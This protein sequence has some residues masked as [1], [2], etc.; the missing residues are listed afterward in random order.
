MNKV[1]VLLVMLMSG[2][3]ALCGEFTVSFVQDGTL[4]RIQDLFRNSGLVTGGNLFSSA[5]YG[6]L[7]TEGLFFQCNN[8]DAFSLGAINLDA[9]R[10]AGKR[11]QVKAE[12]KRSISVDKKFQ[13]GKL[14]ITY[15]ANGRSEWPGA[16]MMPGNFDWQT[17]NLDCTVPVDATDVQLVM[18]IQNGTGEVTYRSLS[19]RIEDTIVDLHTV[20]NMEYAD[21]VAGDGKGGW[22]DQGRNND[23]SGF[24]YSKKSFAGIPF[25]PLSPG[26]PHKTILT[27]QSTRF[28]NGLQEAVCPVGYSK[29]QGKYIYLLHT[30]TWGGGETGAV[31]FVDIVGSDN[32]M[33]TIPVRA[34]LDVGDWWHATKRPNGFPAGSWSNNEGGIVSLYASRFKLNEDLGDI[35][36]VR[37]RSANS[38]A[39]WIVVAATISENEYNFPDANAVTITV[40]KEWGLPPK[41]SQTAGIRAGS[42]LDL[43]PLF[44]AQPVDHTGRVV[45]NKQGLLAY[46]SAPEKPVR[47]LTDAVL[48]APFTGFRNDALELSDKDATKAYV[49]ELVRAGYNMVRFHFMDDNIM[50]NATNEFEFHAGIQDKFDYLVYCMKQK[51]IYISLDAMARRIGYSSGNN[52]SPGKDD[53]RN[54]K[55]DIYFNPIVRDNW[56]KGVTKFLSHVNPYT[57]MALKDDPALA[58]IVGYNEQEFAWSVRD[59]SGATE[60]WRQYLRDKYRDIHNLNDA[61]KPSTPYQSFTDIPTP[62]KKDA[63]SDSPLG[64][65]FDSFIFENEVALLQWYVATLRK[66]GTKALVANFNCGQDL[67]RMKT[68]SYGDFVAMN[69]YH[70][71]P[72]G[73]ISDPR[74]SIATGAQVIRAF[75][76]VRECLKPLVITEHC[77]GFW[78]RYRY[79]QGFI[80]GGY[81]SLQDISGLTAFA[82]SITAKEKSLQQPISTFNLKT[83]PILKAQ[84]M[85]TAFA[86]R[87]E[88]VAPARHTVNYCLRT[89]SVLGSN[90]SRDGMYR[91]QTYAAL[92]NKI[93][94]EVDPVPGKERG[95]IHYPICG[96]NPIILHQEGYQQAVDAKDSGQFDF[97]A[98]IRQMKEKQ[99]LPESNASDYEGEVFQS[100]TGEL[101]LDANRSFMRIDTPRLQGVCALA[102]TQETLSDVSI[103][104]ITSEGNLA[105]IAI[106]Q[107]NPIRVAKRLLVIYATNALNSNMK[108]EDDSFR[109]V[110]AHGEYPYLVRKGAFSVQIQV[111][112]PDAFKAYALAD[113]GTWVE[114]LPIHR[115]K[116]SI[117]LN[118]NTAELSSG[119]PIYFELTTE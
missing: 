10:V 85:I 90:R 28:P 47:F 51:G 35:A 89:E 80:M 42:A 55:F 6:T 88:D 109:T 49:D 61:W 1:F 4:Q 59:F 17:V 114:E 100:A 76:S 103:L 71:H 29:T 93:M 24:D 113:D 108:F 41:R 15:R 2:S 105:V 39:I 36:Q 27:F 43:S 102:N 22:S 9:R 96:S 12:V 74:S 54:Y 66:I 53:T 75:S 32:R 31:G 91:A 73:N 99:I 92:V 19:I 101:Y 83:D 25:Q 72:F 97:G 119:V 87:R 64:R 14:M 84:E 18:G 26:K 78:N 95:D 20:A 60:K 67:L 46:E 94:V 50:N 57:G 44:S 70:A 33:M 38:G 117:R 21:E 62:Q 68:R 77:H 58:L 11:V 112:H 48:R 37:F 16:Y 110:L 81:A 104:K 107:L 116:G 45:V 8:S 56:E 7:S 82:S 34:S 5:N 3:S 118:V 106:D 13:G 30:L 23:G 115:E 111:M 79:E 63:S 69:G 86:Y 52:W 98:L 65:D 40:G